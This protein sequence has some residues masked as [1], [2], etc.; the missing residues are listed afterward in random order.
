MVAR[1]GVAGD[2]DKPILVARWV[3]GDG[4]QDAVFLASAEEYGGVCERCASVAAGPCVY[5]AF[6]SDGALL[7]VG[8]TDHRHTRFKG[9]EKRSAWWPL[10]AEIRCEDLPTI[11]QA[12]AAEMTA[13]RTEHPMHNRIGRRSRRVGEAA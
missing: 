2:D 9:H 4:A 7:Y 1:A 8:S 12:R 10:M 3:C 13:I 6:D 11:D 5:R